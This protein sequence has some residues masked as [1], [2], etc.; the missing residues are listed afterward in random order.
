MR[1]KQWILHKDHLLPF[2]RKLRKSRSLVAPVRNSYG[3]T[4]YTEM[5][6]LDNESIELAEQPQ[7]SLKSF[8]FPQREKLCHYSVDEAV[9]D[10]AQ[11][12]RFYPS[13]PESR[14]VVY[15]GV[16]SCDMFAVMYCDTI[17]LGG[18]ERD[19]YYDARRRNALF[20]T[21]A[22]NHPFE[23]CFC[24]AARTGPYLEMG[25]DLQFTDLGD[26]YFVE[27]DKARGREVVQQWPQFF[28]PAGDDDRQAHYQAA[29]ESRGL[30]RRQVHVDLAVQLLDQG[31][32]PQ[33]LL[34]ELSARC[35]DCGGCAFICPTCTCFN[36]VDQPL[37]DDRGERVRTWDAC[38]FDG[39][40][41]MAGN[42]NSVQ[43]ISQRVTK[44][45]YH[46][47]RDDV[48]RHGRSSCV[49]CGRCVGMCF[50]GVDI[51]RFIDG[52][53]AADDKRSE[54]REDGHD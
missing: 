39:F 6:D 35:Q 1:R 53:C 13:L 2:L 40:T 32:E 16:R 22:C 23:N 36:I 31:E 14:A 8:F 25:Y 15:F 38:T 48:L 45:F 54:K 26:R 3:D 19:V 7:N 49:G 46:K 24:N 33:A 44:R 41:R 12:Y 21:L 20:I 30:F 11:A 27:V 34:A 29:L 28:V 5:N 10:S 47:L 4:M 9:G 50:G 43:I 17:F 37:S 42:H 51:V 52:L 18:R